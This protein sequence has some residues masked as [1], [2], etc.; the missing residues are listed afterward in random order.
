MLVV[1]WGLGAIAAIVLSFSATGRFRLQTAFSAANTEQARLLAAAGTNVA[2]V[3]LARERFASEAPPHNGVPGFCSI[4]DAALAISIE[5]EGGKID[6]NAATEE[7]LRDAFRGLAGLG[8][9][10]ALAAARAVVQFR[11]PAIFGAAAPVAG[12]PFRSKGGPFQTALELD[13]VANLDQASVQA[14]L[15][16][17][18]VYSHVDGLDSRRAPPALLA[19]LLG[20]SR[21]QIAIL[22]AAPFPNSLN[23]NDT[24]FPSAYSRDV[25]HDVFMVHVEVRLSN[26]ARGLS[27][28]I[29]DFQAGDGEFYILREVHLGASRF[30]RELDTMSVPELPQC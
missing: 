16:F 3:R 30:S 21:E 2:I 19:A 15:P 18:T 7:L 28:T 9:A 29:V 17:A 6:L 10:Q 1:I 4:E 26:G 8:P 5:D 27:E 14:I 11:T 23:R 24:R 25:A 13:Q 12:K 22:A 20:G